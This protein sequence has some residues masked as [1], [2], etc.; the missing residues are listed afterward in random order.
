[1]VELWQCKR[2]DYKRPKKFIWGRGKGSGGG[3]T[4]GRGS[5]G[6]KSRSGY[7]KRSTWQGGTM[8]RIR[9]L[10]KKGFSNDRFA[11][12]FSEVNITRLN[13]FKDGEEVT[14]QSLLEKNIISKIEKDGVKILGNGELMR[15]ITVKAHA[16][17]K[18]AKE[19]ILKAGGSVILIK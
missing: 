16:F 15:K 3:K 12:V 18:Q 9:Q 6:Q 10:P 1:M 5:E 11:K 14:P 19:K 4:C 8:P 7:S 2:L 13:V 17:S